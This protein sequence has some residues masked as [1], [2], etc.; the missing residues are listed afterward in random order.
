[1]SSAGDDKKPFS[2]THKK[3]DGRKRKAAGSS[4]LKEGSPP[5]QSEHVSKKDASEVNTGKIITKPNSQDVLLGRGR[6]YQEFAGNRRMLQIVSSRKPEYI[7]LPRDQKRAFVDVVL[8]DVT[9]NGARF[10]KKIGE[11]AWEEVSLLEATQKVW[12][13]L[14]TKE[15]TEASPLRK[16]RKTESS[17][18]DSEDDVPAEPPTIQSLV[19]DIQFHLAK[20]T[21]AS[22]NLA[23]LLDKQ[24]GG[25][26]DAATRNAGLARLASVAAGHG[27]SQRAHLQY[28]QGRHISEA[29]SATSLLAS[30]TDT[31]E[32][33]RKNGKGDNDDAPSTA[34]V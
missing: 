11:N 16:K 3:A 23:A 19:Q 1:M 21:E 14:R 30:L 5:S 9:E 15:K 31:M 20:A 32:T 22:N 29:T 17:E 4:R 34:A 7:A 24:D 28:Q 33:P 27:T 2:K 12:H 6:P 8:A 26:P 13:A 25:E 10:L 18:L